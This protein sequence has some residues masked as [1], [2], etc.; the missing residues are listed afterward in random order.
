MEHLH[1]PV[2]E[3][4]AEEG[5]QLLVANNY[6]VGIR[7]PELMVG[8]PGAYMV[9][10][11]SDEEGG[12]CMLGDDLDELT[13]RAVAS[14]ANE[15][16]IPASGDITD[17]ALL[18]DQLQITSLVIGNVYVES[19]QDQYHLVRRGDGEDLDPELAQ[20][21]LLLRVYREGGVGTAFCHHVDAVQAPLSTTE[22]ICIARHRMDV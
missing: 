15:F 6:V 2:G 22:C 19:G 16:S 1:K 17:E 8:Q 7:D 3:M 20:R 21:W 10:D 5:R 18:G 14:L 12:F 4:T 13:L 11:P 9:W